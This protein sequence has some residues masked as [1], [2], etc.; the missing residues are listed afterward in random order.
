MASITISPRE[1]KRLSAP[2]A[3]EPS[4]LREM[5]QNAEML[6]AGVEDL[7][8]ELPPKLREALTALAYETT[9]PPEGIAS[10]YRAAIRGGLWYARIRLKG[11]QEAFFD[12]VVAHRRLTNAILGAIER[13][14]LAYQQALSEAVEGAFSELERSEA[15]TPEETRE[16]LRRLSNEALREL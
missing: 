1:I 7:W 3:A 5:A 9:E 12:Y 4:E 2:D 10:R 15:L 11:E 6:A 8:T 16:Q 13:D 14:N